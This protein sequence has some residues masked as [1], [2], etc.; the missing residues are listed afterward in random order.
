[1]KIEKALKLFSKLES[2][3][4]TQNLI[5]QSWAKNILIEAEEPKENFPHFNEELE[6]QI[7]IIA[8]SYL[9]IACSLATSKE[10]GNVSVDAFEKAGNILSFVHFPYG[11]RVEKSNYYLLLSSLAFYLSS[12]YSK[13]YIVVKRAEESSKFIRLI[14]LFLK[15]DFK[16]LLLEINSVIFNP[17]CSDAGLIK[18]EDE[19]EANSKIYTVILAKALNLVLEFVYSGRNDRLNLAREFLNDLKILTKINEDPAAWWISRLLVLL[20]DTFRQFSLWSILPPL[21]NSQKTF[22]YIQH[23]AFNSPSIVELFYSQVGAIQAMA[24]DENIVISLPTSSG[25]TRSKCGMA[26]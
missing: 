16:N 13:S 4:F 21:I 19:L 11:G 3:S 1:M 8:L 26:R 15:K 24:K 14:S 7:N 9:N 5:A 12:Q 6:S 20:L 22:A 10:H 18:L 17:N 2:D 25:K 23:L